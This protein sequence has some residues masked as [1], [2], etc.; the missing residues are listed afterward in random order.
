MLSGDRRSWWS[1]S[2]IGTSA[3]TASASPTRR[4]IGGPPARSVGALGARMTSGGFGGWAI[5]L[6]PS[7]RI[8]DVRGQIT[9]AF[10][11]RGWRTPQF[12]AAPASHGAH[13][14]A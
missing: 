3:P 1:T 7:D 14:V 12:L 5:T 4:P 10:S 9:R 8:G 11:E 13:R 2:T 6:V